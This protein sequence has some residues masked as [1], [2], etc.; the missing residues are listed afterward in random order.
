MGS[1][2][3]QIA[4]HAGI[5]VTLADSSQAACEGG[6]KLITNSLTR[7]ARKAHPDS[8]TAQRQL[9]EETCARI[10]TVTEPER[11]AKDSDLVIEAIVEKLRPKQELFKRLDQ[12][13]P[14]S[15]IFAS[16]TSSLKISDIASATSQA[17]QVKFAGLHFFK[18]SQPLL[19][20]LLCRKILTA[21][22]MSRRMGFVLLFRQPGSSDEVSGDH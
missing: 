14:T 20:S 22:L 9:V 4:A 12:I 17:R 3:A 16:N 21:G 7:V 2:I 11:G 13:A 5:R 1:G 6:L 10:T 8:E 18:L 15:A 19:F